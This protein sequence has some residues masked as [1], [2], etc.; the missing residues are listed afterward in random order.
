MLRR[1]NSTRSKQLANLYMMYQANHGWVGPKDEQEFRKF[2]EEVNPQ[3]LEKMGVEITDMDALFT[4]ER[5]GEPFKVRYGIHGGMGASD[6]VIF[7]TKGK[8]GK[9]MVGF[10]AMR[11][12][13]VETD[14]EF[15]QL[16]EGNSDAT[17]PA[18]EDAYGDAANGR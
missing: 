9:R 11:Q 14:A 10:T 8:G 12:V 7:E 16:W 15:N 2:I 17:R 18:R 13:E 6:P 3:S 1:S 5:D 4:S